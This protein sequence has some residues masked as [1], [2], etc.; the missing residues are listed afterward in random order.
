MG[1]VD[2][3]VLPEEDVDLLACI[4][5]AYQKLDY[6][7]A[8]SLIHQRLD[9]SVID[10]STQSRA[11]LYL[12]LACLLIDVAKASNTRVDAEI[13]LSILEENQSEFLKL[14][15][16]SSLAYN[17]GNAKHSLFT[18]D[19]LSSTFEYTPNTI[20][21]LIEAK[22][23]YLSA[24]KTLTE[25]DSRL[26][27]KL[28]VNLGTV[29]SESGRISEAILCYDQAIEKIP[30]FQQAHG[31]RA[32][33]LVWL[34]ILTEK[35]SKMMLVH[36]YNGLVVSLSDHSMPPFYRRD[37]EEKLRQTVNALNKHGVYDIDQAVEEYLDAD[38]A[39]PLSDFQKYALKHGLFL[40]E[41]AIYCYCPEGCSDS[42]DFDESGLPIS[43]AKRM[44]LVLERVKSEFVYARWLYWESLNGQKTPSGE[45]W[46]LE[47]DSNVLPESTGPR[48][49]ML[50]DSYRTTYSILDKVASALL[51]LFEM[52][53]PPKKVYFETLWKLPKGERTENTQYR[54]PEMKTMERFPLVGLFSLSTDLDRTSGE[55]SHFKSWRNAL[56]H[57][58]MF[59][60][61]A[62]SPNIEKHELRKYFEIATERDMQ[63]QCL[64][65]L[66]VTAG[67]IINFSLCVKHSSKWRRRIQE[68]EN[69][70]I[71]TE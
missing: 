27:P 28:L 50:R 46:P 4:E 49:E 57:R 3:P 39:T 52:P 33:D 41:S 67:A 11:L 1:T 59:I 38:R 20:E 23:S 47:S 34:N 13:G 61:N 60:V 29:L 65:L 21:L 51:D 53:S 62:D 12:Q 22:N 17:I 68:S 56:E 26:L 45:Y 8:S 7:T 19:R 58:G 18:I 44:R 6:A 32:V 42:L 64:R 24:M 30:D 55:W 25:Y 40:S 69:Q 71:T 15:T 48:T 5:E 43:I 10:V 35:Y 63:E 16:A 70:P 9:S 2:K 37:Q 66:Q 31:C 54:W 36:V 14:T